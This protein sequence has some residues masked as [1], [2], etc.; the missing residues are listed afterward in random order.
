MPDILW[1]LFSQHKTSEATKVQALATT[2]ISGRLPARQITR[3]GLFLS[4]GEKMFNRLP[5]LAYYPHPKTK[6]N[7]ATVLWE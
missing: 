3:S 6:E 7:P 4:Q 5:A 1:I 2:V